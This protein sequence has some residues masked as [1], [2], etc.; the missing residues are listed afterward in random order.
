MFT[1]TMINSAGIALAF[2][3]LA[4]AA[5]APSPQL[6][7]TAQLKLADTTIDRYSI[8]D[9]DTDFVYDFNKGPSPLANRKVFP[10]LEGTGLALAPAT[11]PPCTIAALH[12][13]PRAAEIFY[14]VSGKLQTRMIPESGAIDLV[15]KKQRVVKTVLTSNQTTIFPQGS[16]HMQMNAE[17]Q[18]ATVV[19]AFSSDDPGASL[20]IPGLFELDDGLLLDSFGGSLTK[21]DLGEIRRVL[22]TDPIFQVDECKKKCVA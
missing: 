15:T 2:S 11:V 16:F 10:A 12:I 1:N 21:A 8:L 13:H 14:V 9:K 18:P 4:S 7:I 17:C 6:S 3:L 20:I 5:P 19:V 22:E